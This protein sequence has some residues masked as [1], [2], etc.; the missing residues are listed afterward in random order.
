MNN[1]IQLSMV[2]IAGTD[3]SIHRL[4]TFLVARG[5]V[6]KWISIKG[7]NLSCSEIIRRGY[8][9]DAAINLIYMKGT[10]EE[11]AINI[12]GQIRQGRKNGETI[13]YNLSI[14]FYY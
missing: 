6:Q 4:T 1:Q 5:F 14:L 7:T 3:S 8:N 10:Q 9:P 13:D 12:L 11:I 2:V